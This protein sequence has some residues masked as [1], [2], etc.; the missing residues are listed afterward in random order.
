MYKAAFLLAALAA[1]AAAQAPAVHVSG[2]A[3]AT[4]PAQTSGAVYL[5]L[6]NGGG[7]ADRLVAVSSTASA[8][9]SIHSTSTTGGVVRMRAVN[10]VALAPNQMVTM[11]PGGLH[12]MLTG[13][14]APLRVGQK[15]A[16]TLRFQRAGIVRTSIPVQAS[17]GTASGHHGH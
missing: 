13:L 7:A 11:K 10:G 6:H 16:L 17:E 4:A 3:R 2:W 9:A 5:S 8:A 1:P 12:V 15:L 14:K